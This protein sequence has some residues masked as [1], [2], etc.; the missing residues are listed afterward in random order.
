MILYH[1]VKTIQA[2]ACIVL[3]YEQLHYSQQIFFFFVIL[4]LPDF[5]LVVRMLF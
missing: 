3:T 4:I 2:D 5:R 1:K